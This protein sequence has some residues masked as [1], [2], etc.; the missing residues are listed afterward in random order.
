MATTITIDKV[1]FMTLAVVLLVGFSLILANA[2][3][4][5]TVGHSSDDI[6]FSSG[7]SVS[8]QLVVS[9]GP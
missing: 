9:G 5:S 6:D 4:P 8:E 2:G 1:H 3:N 7:I